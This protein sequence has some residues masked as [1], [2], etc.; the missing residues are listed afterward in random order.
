[1]RRCWLARSSRI[2]AAGLSARCAHSAWYWGTWSVEFRADDGGTA[3]LGRTHMTFDEG[4]LV[5]NAVLIGRF[6]LAKRPEVAELAGQ[7]GVRP[8]GQA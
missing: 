1:M 3:D 7:Q 4:N 6:L 2:A 8:L 5:P